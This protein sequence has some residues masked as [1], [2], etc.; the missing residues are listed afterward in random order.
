MLAL[1]LIVVTLSIVGMHQ[2]SVGHEVATGQT[3]HAHFHA[4]PHAHHSGA[5]A[6]QGVATAAQAVHRTSEAGVDAAGS[7][8]PDC[9]DHRMALGTCLLA[10]TLLV[11]SWTPVPPRF[12]HLPPFLLPRV[13]PYALAWVVGRLVPSLSLT[14]LSLR[15]T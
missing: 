3:A 8:C 15:R 14:E 6:M 12:R 1:S 11:L 10:L 2:L 7:A 9:P 4:V 5:Q 13:A